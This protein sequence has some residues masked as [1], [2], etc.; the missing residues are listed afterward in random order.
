MFKIFSFILLFTSFSV[1]AHSD[2]SPEEL[3]QLKQTYERESAESKRLRSRERLFCGGS[4]E[5]KMTPY[6]TAQENFHTVCEVS[7]VDDI[8]KLREE[9]DS[10]TSQIK[11]I[12]GNSSEY[13]EYRRLSQEFVDKHGESYSQVLHDNNYLQGKEPPERVHLSAIQVAEA[14][15]RWNAKSESRTWDN[16]RT[17]RENTRGDMEDRCKKEKNDSKITKALEDLEL[18]QNNC[19]HA[20]V[21]H[22][23]HLPR[24]YRARRKYFQ[25]KENSREHSQKHE[26]SEKGS[27]SGGR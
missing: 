26:Q 17:A 14:W 22:M 16:L 13:Q 15:R 19:V 9:R 25:Y 7:Q 24:L 18:V 20:M 4:A 12:E 10:L 27:T 11:N 5:Q 2:I 3:D 8:V 1:F 6:I 23:N 21:N